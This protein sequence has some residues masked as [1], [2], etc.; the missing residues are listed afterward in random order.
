MRSRKP[1]A[2]LLL[3]IEGNLTIILLEKITFQKWQDLPPALA[4]SIVSF[5][6][7][8]DDAAFMEGFPANFRL[9]VYPTTAEKLPAHIHFSLTF[10]PRATTRFF[11][12]QKS[13]RVYKF[14]CLRVTAAVKNQ[15]VNP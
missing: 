3:I 5:N 2:F 15:L 11:Y 1:A 13:S 8:V 14:T 12:T 4:K 7:S 6:I 9:F 10:A